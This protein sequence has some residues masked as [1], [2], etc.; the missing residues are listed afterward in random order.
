MSRPG[1]QQCR[2]ASGRRTR[3]GPVWRNQRRRADADQ[4]AAGGQ[5]ASDGG[6]AAAC[7][8]FMAG[9]CGVGIG[10]TAGS[11]GP[12]SWPSP[13]AGEGA[14]V[15]V[16]QARRVGG[17]DFRGTALTPHPAAYSGH[18]P[19]QGRGQSTVTPALR[20]SRRHTGAAAPGGPGGRSPSC[21]VDAEQVIDRRQHVLR[22][23]RPVDRRRADR[24]RLADHRAAGNPA[25]GEEVGVR[26]APVAAAVALAASACG[27]SRSAPAPACR[28]AARAASRSSISAENAR[29]KPGSRSFFS[30]LR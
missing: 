27:P 26:P 9:A 14:A 21:R 18:P 30:R 3:P 1:S 8:S 7:G 5:A 6:G 11:S 29:S 13:L 19:P 25:A 10:A 28:R 12:R 15:C 2:P 24:V 16:S 22:R 17:R 20:G 23:Q 4:V